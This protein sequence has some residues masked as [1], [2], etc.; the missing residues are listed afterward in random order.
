VSGKGTS[1]VTWWRLT[2]PVLPLLIITSWFVVTPWLGVDWYGNWVVNQENGSLSAIQF[3]GHNVQLGVSHQIGEW[4]IGEGT[5]SVQFLRWSVLLP[6]LFWCAG[7]VIGI[8]LVVP[9]ALLARWPWEWHVP[10]VRPRS[11]WAVLTVAACIALAFVLG[12]KA[13]HSSL[14]GEDLGSWRA[15]EQR[16]LLLYGTFSTW[17]NFYSGLVLAPISEE[18]FFRGW[19]QRLLTPLCKVWL[20]LILQA[21]VF[22]L[23]HYN[24]Q[25]LSGFLVTGSLGFALGLI[26][27]YT[28]KLWPCILSHALINFHYNAGD[29]LWIWSGRS[30]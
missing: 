20:A 27:I 29:L 17:I 9:L 25:G 2:W 3:F 4:W 15:T 13:V 18:I 24:Y 28:G 1:E 16:R 14:Y 6:E 26:F 21:I 19:L 8:L 11:P 22:G 23:V 30:G 7:L 5:P 10:K 12:A